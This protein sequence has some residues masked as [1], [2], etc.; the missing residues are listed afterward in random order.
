MDRVYSHEHLL[1]L[2]S[3]LPTL[4]EAFEHEEQSIGT[5]AGECLARM[6]RALSNVVMAG[7]TSKRAARY[8]RVG[9][10]ASPADVCHFVQRAMQTRI[11]RLCARHCFGK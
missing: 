6:F 7:S 5:L 11:A 10:R 8:D 3:V 1:Q 9:E 4:C 2:W